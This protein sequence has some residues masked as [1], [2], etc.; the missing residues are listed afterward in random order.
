MKSILVLI[1][2]TLLYILCG[3]I[4]TVFYYLGKKIEDKDYYFDPEDD[5]E[6]YIWVA[7]LWPLTFIIAVF[8]FIPKK[9]I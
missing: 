9:V 8:V 7:I 2:V 6:E 4:M 1:C 5:T 3:I